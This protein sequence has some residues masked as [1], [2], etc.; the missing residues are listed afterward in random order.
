MDV[1]VLLEYY[2]AATVHKKEVEE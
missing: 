1:V 2:T